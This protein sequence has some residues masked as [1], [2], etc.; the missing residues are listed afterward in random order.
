MAHTSRER[1]VRTDPSLNEGK[2]PVQLSESRRF[3]TA[4]GNTSGIRGARALQAFIGI[5]VE[6]QVG[7][8]ERRNLRGSQQALGEAAAGGE[9]DEDIK[10]KGYNEAFDEVEATN[11]LAQFAK[12]L[13]EMLEKEGWLDLSP[14]DA[15]ERIDAYYSNQ[16][17]G[18]NSESVYG[19]IVAKGILKQNEELLARHSDVQLAKGQQERRIMVSEATRSEYEETG[20]LDHEKLMKR[21]KELVP[22]PGGRL[23]YIESVIDLAEEFGDPSIILSIPDTFPGGDPTGVTDVN[24]KNDVIDPGLT[25]AQA[26]KDRNEKDA[27]DQFNADFQTER[28]AMH[29]S[30]TTAAKAGD[31]GVIADIVAGGEDGPNGE[32]RLL[33]RPQQKTL[34]DQLM[35]AQQANS[36][37]RVDGDLFGSARAF[38]MT[39]TDYDLAAV[40]YAADV[41]E[42]Y[43]REKPEWDDDKVKAETLKV[44]IERSFRHDRVPKYI[45]D[46]LD[47]TPANPERFKEA[48][49]IKA[50]LDAYDPTLF[51]RTVSDRNAALMGAYEF[52]LI[53]TGDDGAALDFVASYDET[54][55]EG[56]KGDVSDIAD[57]AL[58]NLAGDSG[59]FKSDFPITRA[60]RVRARKLGEHY[61][62]LGY[63]D[64]RVAS[65]IETGMRERNIRVNGTLYPSDFGWIQGEEAANAYM[66]VTP[67]NEFFTE[68]E[69]LVMLPHLTKNGVVTIS[70]STSVLPGSL[71][72]VRVS[73][74]EKWYAKSQHDQLVK[75]AAGAES[76]VDEKLKEA[77]NRAFY[78]AHPPSSWGKSGDRAAHEKRSRA[79][80]KAMDSEQRQRLIEAQ[81]KKVEADVPYRTYTDADFDESGEFIRDERFMAGPNAIRAQ[82]RPRD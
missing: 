42:M 75:L 9:R 1:S 15:Q 25:K 54:R 19:Q 68:S 23:T 37:S 3:F 82:A 34:F 71:L 28:A 61:I 11:D 13:P 8:L 26:K 73:E 65:F 20:T 31:A 78:A 58:E 56:R 4:Q 48:V 30:L 79:S 63:G 45:A 39:D 76:G 46:F 66:R 35:T 24:F 49:N 21:L 50:M 38:G 16:L 55:M 72:E 64:E 41:S 14:E 29:S 51:N 2:R 18:I 67:G 81:I 74:I 57:I 27:E 59:F 47:A 43:R 53:D 62:N 22:G 70:D 32:P 6:A 44:I 60:D 80:W 36:V 77:E 10:N 52:A 12:E 33:S 69:N 40:S 5:G 7:V 17:K